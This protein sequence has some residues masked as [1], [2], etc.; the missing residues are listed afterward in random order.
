[1]DGIFDG[2]MPELIS[3]LES[4]VK[5]DLT[6]VISILSK[7]EEIIV[8]EE[9][10]DRNSYLL[11]L[12]SAM[13]KRLTDL[14]ERFV[15][16]QIKAISDTPLT[17]R[18]RSGILTFTRTFPVRKLVQSQ[19]RGRLL[20]LLIRCLWIAWRNAWRDGRALLDDSSIRVM[21]ESS[22]QYF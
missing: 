18:K 11:S 17:L 2:L 20:M 12:I 16:E 14:F 19:F 3:L 8:K 10:E 21:S 6:F 4:C 15:E 13:Q 1:M 9:E 7:V 22:R 5:V